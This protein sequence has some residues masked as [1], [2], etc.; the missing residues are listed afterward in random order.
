VCVAAAAVSINVV[1]GFKYALILT[2]IDAE[3]KQIKGNF[4]AT[5]ISYGARN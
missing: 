5:R 2:Q 1:V 4:A 3:K